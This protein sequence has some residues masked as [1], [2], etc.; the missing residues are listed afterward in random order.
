MEIHQIAPNAVSGSYTFDIHSPC[1]TSLP[2]SPPPT[3]TAAQ[4][5][6]RPRPL[7]D[8]GTDTTGSAGTTS[9]SPKKLH[10]KSRSTTACPGGARGASNPF[11]FGALRRSPPAIAASQEEPAAVGAPEP[12][13]E[14]RRSLGTAFSF[15]QPRHGR[16][17]VASPSSPS[18]PASTQ[19]GASTSGSDDGAAAE[20]GARGGP[21]AQ[22]EVRARAD[23][24]PVPTRH[25]A[26]SYF[27]SVRPAPAAVPHHAPTPA[28]PPTPVPRAPSPPLAPPRYDKAQTKKVLK[29]ARAELMKEVGKAGYNVLVVEG[30]VFSRSWTGQ[31]N[32]LTR[33][34]VVQ[35]GTHRPPPKRALPH[36]SR[37]PRSPCRRPVR[38]G[39]GR[40]NA[41]PTPPTVPECA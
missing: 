16:D 20:C 39:G 3:S 7:S 40:W 19:S 33:G 37:L 10:R 38:F 8:P 24:A 12:R 41:G 6:Q 32:G 29:H 13:P 17:R 9:Y 18:S 34:G 26:G 1:R 21:A 35:V 14:R 5:A 25:S 31:D 4:A 22:K 2:A 36:Q 27:P 11:T 15:L 28:A 30:C 23:A